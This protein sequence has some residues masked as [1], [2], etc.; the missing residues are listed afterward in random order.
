MLGRG[1]WGPAFRCDGKGEGMRPPADWRRRLPSLPRCST[2]LRRT[3]TSE[4]SAATKKPLATTRTI[5]ATS[6]INTVQSNPSIN[7]RP[8][9]LKS[10]ARRRSE[11]SVEG[12]E[13]PRQSVRCLPGSG[14]SRCD[15]RIGSPDFDPLRGRSA[16]SHW[17]CRLLLPF[18][19][20]RPSRKMPR[21]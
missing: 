21:R 20:A 6:L 13:A 4:N 14:T 15:R 1:G 11:L 16:T 8:T 19:P 17:S 9:A 12:R 18:W 5:T 2:R 3:A 10:V 7:A